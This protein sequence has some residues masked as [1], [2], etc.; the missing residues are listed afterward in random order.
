MKSKTIKAIRLSILIISLV[1]V[2]LVAVLHQVMG[3]GLFPSIH[4]ICPFGGLESLYS[5]FRSGAFISKIYSGTF[6]MFVV[7]VV[8][9]LVFRRSFC[10][11]ICPFGTLQ[12]LFARLGKK[13]LGKRL[14]MPRAIDKPLRYLK[15]VVLFVTVLYA[16]RTAGL[17]VTPYDPWSAYA[18]LSEGLANVWKESAIGLIVLIITVLGSIVYD[19]FFC[20]YL[21]PVGALYGIIG[22]LSRYR[23]S[24]DKDKC[25]SCGLCTKICPVNIDV[26]N[27]DQVTTAECISCQQC[28]LSCPKADTLVMKSGKK[29]IKPFTAI[30]LVLVLFLVPIILSRSFGLFNVLP[31]KPKAGQ[32]IDASEIKGYM[33]IKEAAEFSRI[34]VDEFYEKFKIPKTVPETTKMKEIET[35]VPDYNFDEIKGSFK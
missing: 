24:R 31:D 33:T 11:L 15:Y 3:G 25:I 10:G 22:K 4:A 16:W 30:I 8:L 13:I 21:C 23:V 6:I 35:I 20:K 28:V 1:W 18:H 26:A 7:T 12:E 19:R 14:E 9:A 17:W 29:V 27:K 34:D 2:S 32:V 5:V